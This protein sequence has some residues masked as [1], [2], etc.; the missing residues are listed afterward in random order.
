M[1]ACHI[2]ELL[3]TFLF[4]TVILFTV[5][6]CSENKVSHLAPIIIS[7]GLMVSIYVCISA[8]GGG[9]LNP[10]VSLSMYLDNKLKTR[11]FI[12]NVCCQ[13][14]GAIVA[15]VVFWYVVDSKQDKIIEYTETN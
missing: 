7:L 5:K 4:L 14:L 10:V 6:Y 9:H 13:G 1:K 11:D 8:G 3:G 12:G 2:S 15:L